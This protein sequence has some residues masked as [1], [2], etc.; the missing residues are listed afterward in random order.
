MIASFYILCVS[1]FINHFS[2][3]WFIARE[4]ELRYLRKS[5]IDQE[6][7]VSVLDKH[8]ENINNGI[9]KLMDS[10]NQLQE[11]CLKYEQHINKLKSKLL[12]ALASIKFPGKQYFK[13]FYIH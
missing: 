5:V 11:S 2:Y 7:E 3:Y 4:S 1:V 6:Q 10:N 9:I 8:I 12:T 13:L